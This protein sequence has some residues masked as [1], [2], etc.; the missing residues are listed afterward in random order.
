MTFDAARAGAK[1]ANRVKASWKFEAEGLD[2]GFAEPL[3]LP[4]VQFDVTGLDSRNTAARGSTTKLTARVWNTTSDRRGSLS[5][6]ASSD[7]GKT[8]KPATVFASGA[9]WSVSVRN[10]G[11]AAGITL[12]AVFSEPGGVSTTQVSYAAYG[13]R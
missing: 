11:K 10:P 12:K 2:P 4:Q 3:P 1:T 5:V 13:V 7:G 6:Q 8:W 9:T